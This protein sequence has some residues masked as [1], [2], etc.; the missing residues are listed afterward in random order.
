MAG[1]SNSF[2]RETRSSGREAPS[3]KLNA[4]AECNSMYFNRRFL[5]RTS[6]SHAGPYKLDTVQSRFHHSPRVPL[7]P[8]DVTSLSRCPTPHAPMPFQTTSHLFFSR[9]QRTQG[10]ACEHVRNQGRLAFPHG[11]LNSR[12]RHFKTCRV[13]RE[14]QKQPEL[15]RAGFHRNRQH[16]HC[17]DGGSRRVRFEIELQEFQQEFA[18]SRR[19]RKPQCPDM[20]NRFLAPPVFSFEREDNFDL[21]DGK[22][23]H[24]QP[25]KQLFE[26][27]VQDE[28]QRLQQVHRRIQVHALFKIRWKI[29]G[30]Q[31]MSVRALR[32]PPPAEPFLPESLDNR[33]F[34]ETRKFFAGMDAPASQRFDELKRNAQTFERK[35][36]HLKSFVSGW[37]HRHSKEALCRTYRS[38][39]ISGNG[40]VCFK[41]DFRSD[42]LQVVRDLLRRTEELFAASQVEYDAV[43]KILLLAFWP[44][45]NTRRNRPRT[46]E[47]RGIGARFLRNGPPSPHDALE[48]FCL[49]FRHSGFD[50][51]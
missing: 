50:S 42:T 40:N 7:E 44:I 12:E 11:A 51:Q 45:L 21:S 33:N 48:R 3:R 10:F 38:Q 28:E 5:P 18:V 37:N 17:A 30:D 36:S 9:V 41:A 13:R 2:A 31:R 26:Q 14:R 16:R 35:S 29:F 49:H 34:R 19:H 8:W 6:A 22:N 20:I 43:A 1:C 23:V 27:P 39:G 25:R 32:Q 46:V 15:L 47:K 24:A 4:E